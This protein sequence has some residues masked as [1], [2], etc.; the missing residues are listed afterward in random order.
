MHLFLG[1]KRQ[2]TEDGIVFLCA[3]VSLCEKVKNISIMK[4]SLTEDF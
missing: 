1:Y 2:K 3:L 4:I